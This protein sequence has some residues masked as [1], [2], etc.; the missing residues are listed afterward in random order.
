MPEEELRKLSSLLREE[1][2]AREAKR[3]SELKVGD[4]HEPPAAKVVAF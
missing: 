3:T 1:V 4:T 2:P